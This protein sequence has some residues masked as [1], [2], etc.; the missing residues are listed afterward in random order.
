M[1]WNAGPR[2]AAFG[3][4]FMGAGCTTLREVPPSQ[5]AAVPERKHVRVV[6]RDGLRYEFD[7]VSVQGDSLYGYRRRDSEDGPLDQYSNFKLPLE[8]V[9]RLSQ[10]SVDW[11]K[12][13]LIGGGVVV[14]IVAKGLSN[15]KEEP[16]PDGD[17]GGGGRPP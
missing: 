4:A 8:E 7:Y 2:W 10:R 1:K 13:G 15:S 6:T 16:A 9:S 11:F 17:S 5:Y 12:T 3:L 14:A